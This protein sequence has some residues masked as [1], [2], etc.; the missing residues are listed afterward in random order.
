LAGTEEEQKRVREEA[1]RAKR[2]AE[3]EAVSRAFPSTPFA[4]DFD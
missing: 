2:D 3:E 4:G 1:E